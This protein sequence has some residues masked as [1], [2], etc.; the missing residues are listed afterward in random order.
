MYS[1]DFNKIGGGSRNSCSGFLV[2][3]G[4]GS[5]CWLVLAVLASVGY[6]GSRCWLVLASVGYV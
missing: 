5:R 6:V 3:A 2:L 1:V 4:V